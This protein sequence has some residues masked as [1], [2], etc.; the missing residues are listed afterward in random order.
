MRKLV[1]LTALTLMFATGTA[2]ADTFTGVVSDA[3]CANNPTKASSPS[4]AACAKKCI[5]GGSPAVLIV[6]GKV[7]QVANAEKLNSYAGKT[8]TV[9]ASVAKDVLTIKSIKQ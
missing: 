9:D 4:H 8:V 5:D 2:L 3:M 7:Y 1:T 6:N